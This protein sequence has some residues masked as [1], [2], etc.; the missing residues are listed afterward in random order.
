VPENSVGRDEGSTTRGNLSFAHDL[1]L[2]EIRREIFINE[3]K[4]L[5]KEK[6]IGQSVRSCLS[7]QVFVG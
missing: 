7:Q 5:K 6:K 1:R 2:P 4:T 3:P